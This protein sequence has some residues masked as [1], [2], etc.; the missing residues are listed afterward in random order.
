MDKGQRR[1]KQFREKGHERAGACM[2]ASPATDR[3]RGVR[4]QRVLGYGILHHYI[5]Y[6]MMKQ[7]REKDFDVGNW[8]LGTRYRSRRAERGICRV[9]RRIFALEKVEKLTRGASH[10]AKYVRTGYFGLS[11]G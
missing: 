4:K 5:L 9:G 7:R 8:N 11:F 6:I 10:M 2:P 1:R 3:I